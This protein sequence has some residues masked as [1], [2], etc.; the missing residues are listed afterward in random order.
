MSASPH[1]LAQPAGVTASPV[2]EAAQRPH[3]TIRGLNKR[4]DNT[5]VYDDFNLDIPRG[6]L[7]SVFGPNGCGKAP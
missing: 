1:A 2:R 3:V 5:I 4:F 7:I 6:E